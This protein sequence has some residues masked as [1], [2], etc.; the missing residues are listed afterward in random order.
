MHNLT[1]I[2]DTKGNL[3][4]NKKRS[5]FD[6]LIPQYLYI[7]EYPIAPPEI[8]ELKD[9]DEEKRGILIIDLMAE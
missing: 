5:N 9:N 7:E 2:S 1:Y 6:E 8:S 3:M 4:D